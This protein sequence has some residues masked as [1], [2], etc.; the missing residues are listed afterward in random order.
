M[1][2]EEVSTHEEKTTDTS[3]K[4][5]QVSALTSKAAVTKMFQQVRVNTL[6][7]EDRMC[8]YGYRKYKEE[9]HSNFIT[10]KYSNSNKN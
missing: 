8:Q 4:L 9:L 6:E 1:K 5:M 2:N 10:E 3:A 7:V